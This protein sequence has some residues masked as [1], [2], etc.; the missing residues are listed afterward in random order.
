MHEH[1]RSIQVSGQLH[2]A[3]AIQESL[4]QAAR[5]FK[6]RDASVWLLQAGAQLIKPFPGT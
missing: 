4:M 2:K 3:E 5:R 1:Y 6:Q